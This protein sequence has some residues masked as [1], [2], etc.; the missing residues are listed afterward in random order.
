M[1]TKGDG[2][3]VAA[4]EGPAEGAERTRT[5]TRISGGGGAQGS[6][7]TSCSTELRSTWHCSRRLR[8]RVALRSVSGEIRSLG[9]ISGVS[10]GAECCSGMS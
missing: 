10:K 2:S 7:R 3:R 6:G 8:F 9:K 4:A 1:S 5:G